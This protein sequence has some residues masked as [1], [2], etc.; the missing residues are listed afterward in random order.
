[1]KKAVLLL[2]LCSLA[3][4]A[5]AGIMIHPKYLFL[6]DK[7][8]SEQITLINSSAL[9]SANYRVTLNYKKQNPDGSFTEVATEEIPQDSITRL[10][11]Y[12]P[13][14]VILTRARPR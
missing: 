9:E 12:S 6:D 11:R 5:S 13:R 10:L 4:C 2:T 1:M 3:L 8:K 14:S 7:T